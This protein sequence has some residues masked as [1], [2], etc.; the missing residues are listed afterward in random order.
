MSKKIAALLL[1]AT[2]LPFTDL[3]AHPVATGAPVMGYIVMMTGIGLAY[4][5][6]L[7]AY[8]RRRNVSKNQH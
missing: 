6:F 2:A 3:H 8:M 5:F 7:L 1:P 4:F